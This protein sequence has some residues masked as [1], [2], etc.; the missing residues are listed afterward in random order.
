MKKL[1]L[2]LTSVLSIVLFAAPTVVSAQTS[3]DVINGVCTGAEDPTACAGNDGSGVNTLVKTGIRIFQ[4]LV[5]LISVVMIIFGGLRFVMSGGDSGKIASAR[6]TIMY[7]LI[8][9]AVVVLAEVLVHFVINRV[10]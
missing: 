2:I 6:N 3:G 10:A 5:G 9:V 8:G 7:A 4:V 1:L